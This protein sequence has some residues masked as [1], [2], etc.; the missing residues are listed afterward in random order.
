VDHESSHTGRELEL[1]LAGQK[2]LAMF[3]EIASELPCEE[4]IPEEAFASHVQNGRILRHDV[5]LRDTNS[6]GVIHVVRYVFYALPGE[7]WR[8]QLMIVLKRALYAGGGWNET[9]E[10]VE[11]TLLGY[12]DQENDI[13]CAQRFKRTRPNPSLNTDAPKDGAPVS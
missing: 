7:E 6:A 12:S 13:H 1:M 3:Y 5:D 8:I 11:G 4:L 9:C 10:R 2:P